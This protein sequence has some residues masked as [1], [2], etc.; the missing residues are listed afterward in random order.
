MEA[1]AGTAVTGAADSEAVAEEVS[2]GETAEAM[3]AAA[4]AVEDSVAAAT[5]WEEG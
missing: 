1:E 5:K 4:A 2:A 3:E